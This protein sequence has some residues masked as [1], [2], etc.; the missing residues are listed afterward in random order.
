MDG[1]FD[2][3]ASRQATRFDAIQGR[4]D[5]WLVGCFIALAAL[6][7][8]MVASSSLAIA[9]SRD[10]APLYYFNRHAIYLSIGI[11]LAWLVMTRGDIRRIEQHSHLL[12]IIG[13]I[14]LLLVLVPGLGHT[15][16]GARRWISLGPIGFQPAEAVKLILIVWL[17][18]YLARFSDEVKGTWTAMFKAFGVALAFSGILLLLHKDFGTTALVL[19]ITAGMMVLGGVHMPRMVLP[20]L[21]IMPLLVL[22]I[23]LEPYRVQRLV[24]FSDPWKDPFGSGYQLTNALMAVGR[25]EFAGV[26]LGASVQ[27]LS[28]LPEA[29]TDFIMAVIAEELGFVG[30]CLVITL[31]AV[32]VGRAFWIGLQC[33]EMRR[34]FAGYLAFGI[35]LWIA[36]QAFVSIGVNLGLLPTKG[37]TL[38][39]VSSGGSSILVTCVGMGLLLRVSWELERAR[40][41]VALRRDAVL[42]T[43]AAVTVATADAKPANAAATT[44]PKPMLEAA[45]VAAG[46]LAE[47]GERTRGTLSR[48][49]DR[50]PKAKRTESRPRRERVEPSFGGA[51]S[52]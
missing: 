37:L 5:P 32:L 10:L 46:M 40:R 27:K 19:A 31:Y 42:P 4:F 14:I 43:T 30:V 26:G 2:T 45:N 52:R 15:V 25:G 47:A 9:E 48:L 21:A 38:P 34:H 28:Y 50:T 6:G 29:Y 3:A 49:L 22:M 33:V 12:P 1:R 39:L 11:A 20:V 35:G 36:L 7:L 44:S 18:S 13:I 51:S 23:L 24:S 41:Q 16:K 17:A 8:V